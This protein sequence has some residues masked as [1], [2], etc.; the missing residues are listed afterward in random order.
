M[1]NILY[2]HPDIAKRAT[3]ILAK[4]DI[5]E[6]KNLSPGAALFYAWVS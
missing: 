2:L 3:E 5:D 4:H 6:L 1:F